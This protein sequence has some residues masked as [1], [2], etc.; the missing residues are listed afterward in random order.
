MRSFDTGTRG[1]ALPKCLDCLISSSGLQCVIIL[2]YLQRGSTFDRVQRLRTGQAAQSFRAN[3][4]QLIAISTDGDCQF[5]ALLFG[6][7]YGIVFHAVTVAF[8][9][10]GRRQGLQPIRCN[11]SEFIQ[12]R[13]CGLADTFKPAQPPTRASSRYA[14]DL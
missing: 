12:R 6:L 13:A 8:V 1:K 5:E 10:H 11:D 9:S 3:S 7:R 14:G 4:Q 2:A